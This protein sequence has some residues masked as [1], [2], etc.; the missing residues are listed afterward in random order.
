MYP[1]IQKR[2]GTFDGDM[3]G[4]RI[5]NLG[6]P[7]PDSDAATRQ[8]VFQ[9]TQGVLNTVMSLFLGV[10]VQAHPTQISMGNQRLT[11]LAPPMR[12]WDAATKKYVDDFVRS[13]NGLV[14]RYFQLR[15]RLPD[16]IPGVNMLTWHL[17]NT[18]GRFP[19]QPGWL[20]VTLTPIPQTSSR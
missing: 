5:S 13:A 17:A 9:L 1:V 2:S 4:R 14:R 19:T 6:S 20:L 12:P 3:A 15:F 7:E 18:G 11:E 8:T 10:M 16:D